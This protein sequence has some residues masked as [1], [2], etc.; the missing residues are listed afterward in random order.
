MLFTLIYCVKKIISILLF[1]CYLI[2]VCDLKEILKIEKLIEHYQE[3]KAEDPDTSIIDF[4]TMHY[5]TD[6]MNDLAND[7]DMKLPF[8]HSGNFS[9]EQTFA[10]IV[11]VPSS[12]IFQ[13]F[14]IRSSNYCFS[15]N[16]IFILNF[17]T[18]VWHPPQIS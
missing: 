2:T 3:S 18:L 1:S 10:F 11:T 13:T 9:S 15:G 16:S 4:L 17:Q 5:V 12:L 7:Q 6:D 14:A 8:K